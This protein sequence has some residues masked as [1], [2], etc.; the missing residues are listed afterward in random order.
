MLLYF[1]LLKIDDQKK[2]INMSFS[3]F[4]QQLNNFEEML[5]HNNLNCSDLI[6]Q[7]FIISNKLKHEVFIEYEKYNQFK[8][9]QNKFSHLIMQFVYLQCTNN[10]SLGI[11]SD[12]MFYF[13]DIS[14]NFKTQEVKKNGKTVILTEGEFL[15]LKYLIQNKGIKLS[16]N[17]IYENLADCAIGS[18]LENGTRPVDKLIHKLRTKI[19]EDKEFIKSVHNV[20]YVFYCE[21]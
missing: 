6:A 4:K 2:E 5:I 21:K 16:R 12:S 10:I 15:L 1:D 14:I 3:A 17:I 8:S 7:L 20:G 18:D 19:D 13:G 11:T 9:L